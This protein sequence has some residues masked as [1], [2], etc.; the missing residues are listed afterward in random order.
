MVD[1]T[2]IRPR[3]MSAIIHF[4]D[5]QAASMP[6]AW[7]QLL[8][9]LRP[10]SHFMGI[11]PYSPPEVESHCNGRPLFR[12]SLVT[13][14]TAS[15]S[16]R[17]RAPGTSVSLAI[18]LA[19]LL[20]PRSRSRKVTHKGTTLHPPQCSGHSTSFPSNLCSTSLTLFSNSP[21]PTF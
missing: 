3:C 11:S 4:P 15:Y 16:Y 12:R 1:H 13:R 18:T 2:K 6:P 8:S 19:D 21:S 17:S 14:C 10:K 5:I 9:G 7:L 20:R